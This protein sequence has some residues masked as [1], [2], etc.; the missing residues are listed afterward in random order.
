MCS[1]AFENDFF[2]HYSLENYTVKSEQF[3]QLIEKILQLVTPKKNTFICNILSWKKMIYQLKYFKLI[4]LFTFYS[5]SIIDCIKQVS[6]YKGLR[7]LLF[8]NQCSPKF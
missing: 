3:D 5:V 8:I 4:Q 1:S 7:H 6:I 2:W